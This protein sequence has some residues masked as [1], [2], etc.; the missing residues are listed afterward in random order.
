VK[1]LAIPLSHQQTVTKRLVIAIMTDETTGKTTDMTTSHLTEETTSQSTKPPKNGGKVAG[2]NPAN[3]SGQV[4]GYSHPTKQ[5]EDVCQV[6]G[7]AALR[8]KF[9][10]CI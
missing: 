2:Y 9:L 6:S 3:D 5:P 1:P 10:A 8:K 7:Y 4:I